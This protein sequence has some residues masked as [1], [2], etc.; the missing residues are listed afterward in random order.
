MASFHEFCE[1]Y[2]YDPESEEAA[3][4]YQEARES[5]EALEAAAERRKD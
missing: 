3:R 4:D 5:L 1:R 2:G